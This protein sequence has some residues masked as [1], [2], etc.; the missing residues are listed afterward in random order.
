MKKNN[1]KA[2]VNYNEER[3][4]FDVM[5]STDGGETWGLDTSY[6]CQE[7]RKGAPDGEKDF[8]HWHVIEKIGHL[9]DNGYEV[10]VFGSMYASYK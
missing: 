5:I 10:S 6:F 1:L 8:I 2:K 3:D 9:I 4:S 7:I